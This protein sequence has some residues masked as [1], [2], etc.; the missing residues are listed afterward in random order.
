MPILASSIVAAVVVGEVAMNSE[1]VKPIPPSAASRRARARGP[2]R[3]GSAPEPQPAGRAQAPPAIPSGLPTTRP[4]H[5][6]PTRS[7]CESGVAGHAAA[8]RARPALASANSGTITKRATGGARARARSS[9]SWPPTGRAGRQ[10]AEHHAG[11]AWRARPDSSTREPQ[12]R[13]PSSDVDQTASRT[14]SR[15][16]TDD[17]DEPPRPRQQPPSRDRVRV[18]DRDHD[19]RADVVD[20]REREQEQLQ[21]GGHARR[22]AGAA[23]RPRTAMSVAIGMRPAA[24][25]VAAGVDAR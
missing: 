17:R 22:R 8:E 20:D 18:E 24:R 15:R 4:E 12:D 19:D 3:R 6:P 14:P 7:R 13:S 21:A 16:R 5:D 10:Q 23:R 1:T 25:T 11:D 9:T 2:R